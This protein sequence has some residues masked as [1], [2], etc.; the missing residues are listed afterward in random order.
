MYT[1]H[2]SI[3]VC[4]RVCES[5][6][7]WTSKSSYFNFLLANRSSSDEG[8][9]VLQRLRQ[10]CAG[11]S[12]FQH[13]RRRK[14]KIRGRTSGEGASFLGGSGGMHPRKI[15]EICNLYKCIS[16]IFSPFKCIKEVQ[17]SL[18]QSSSFHDFYFL[19]PNFSNLLHCKTQ[20]KKS[21]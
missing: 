18:S 3:Y 4:W 16:C 5:P 6:S 1:L 9:H 2:V 12:Q 13:S 17:K 15:F 19:F 20:N 14:S 7:V 11:F 21:S 10:S 8:T